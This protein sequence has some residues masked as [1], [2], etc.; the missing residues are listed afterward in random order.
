MRLSNVFY[1][2]NRIQAY[3]IVLHPCH[4]MYGHNLVMTILLHMLI[5]IKFAFQCLYGY[6]HRLCVKAR[7]CKHVFMHVISM[8]KIYFSAPMFLIV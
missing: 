8:S 3:T 2:P 5:D 4:G 1:E 7:V 6:E